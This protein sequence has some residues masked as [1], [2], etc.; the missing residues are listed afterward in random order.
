VAERDL[1]KAVFKPFTVKPSAA[2]PS[3]PQDQSDETA[4][5]RMR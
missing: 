3:P 2:T 1:F 5:A 4:P